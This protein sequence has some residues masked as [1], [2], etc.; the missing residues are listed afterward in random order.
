MSR[1][2]EFPKLEAAA[3][4]LAGRKQDLSREE[5]R[6]LLCHDCAFWHDEHEEELECSCFQILR[7]MLSRGSLTPETLAAAVRPEPEKDR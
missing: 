5:L 3:R 6:R 2:D 7:I 4:E 1:P